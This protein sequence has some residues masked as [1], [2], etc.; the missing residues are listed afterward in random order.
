MLLTAFTNMVGIMAL[1][2]TPIVPIRNFAIMSTIGIV[3]SLFLTF[4]LLPILLELWPPVAKV[5]KTR[6]NPLNV[7]GRIIPNFALFLQKILDKI[8]PMVE[9]RPTTYVLVFLI[10]FVI[11]V[12]GASKARV[13][14]SL[15]DNYPKNSRIREN[16]RIVDQKMA[17]SS[18][19]ALYLDLGKEN[20]LQDPKVLNVIDELQHKFEKKY[21]KYVVTTSSIVDIVKES[22]QKLNEGRKEKYSIPLNE[23]AL[24]QTLFMF[25]NA[26]PEERR[27]LID[28]NY[29]K[30]NITIT[31]HNYGSHEYSKVFAEMQEDIYQSMNEIKQ[32]YPEAF[33]SITGVFVLAMKSADYITM[34]EFQDFGI[35]L[36]AISIILLVVF[37]S[38]R[39]GLIALI[40]NLI[41][42][43]LTLGL[44]GFL[45]IPLDFFTM[46]LAP[47][48]IGISVDDTVT[49]ITQ[50][51]FE[52]LKDGDIK[53]ALKH[54]MKEA[55]Q[56]LV[57]TSMIMGLGFCIMSIASTTGTS[58]LGKF[59]ALSVFAGMLNDLFILP[60][61]ILVFKLNY[62]KKEMKHEQF[63]A[64]AIIAACWTMLVV[65]LWATMNFGNTTFLNLIGIGFL[66]ILA[67]FLILKAIRAVL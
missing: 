45:K 53:R 18:R 48:L 33:V 4:Y 30:A 57:F 1:N 43:I 67:T 8:M 2:I 27:R 6:K 38:F 55:G 34:N 44:L 47:V 32:K 20:A 58:N 64:I 61:F 24:S 63:R 10:S 51:R 49:F 7:I 13:D 28:D 14:T 16:F 15:T 29:Q 17:G 54:T 41:P 35:A 46:M 5:E 42:S 66:V 26:N 9:K 50:Y 65:I 52:V 23:K 40:P 25:N 31:L 3:L 59:G 36:I 12:Y 39:A 62:Q 11:C 56:A 37:G 22:N 19:I 60:A 21:S